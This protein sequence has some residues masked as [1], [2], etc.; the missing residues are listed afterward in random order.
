M[1]TDFARSENLIS[2][3]TRDDIEYILHVGMD[4]L[5]RDA[6]LI[7]LPGPVIAAGGL[8]GS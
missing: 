1:L 5:A 2:E 4:C 7:A 8:F 3:L 6:S